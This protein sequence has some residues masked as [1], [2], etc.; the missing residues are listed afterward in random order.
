MNSIMEIHLQKVRLSGFHG[1]D[2]GENILVG[3]FEVSLTA[4]YNP[5]RIPVTE[6][7]ETLDYTVLLG[8]VEKRMAKPTLLLETLATDIGSEIIAKFQI[9]TEVTISIIKLHPP[10]INFRGSVGVTFTIKR[11]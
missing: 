8:M 1:L 6:L 2:A 5:A 11:N 9:V 3:Q 4:I 7:H 10:I